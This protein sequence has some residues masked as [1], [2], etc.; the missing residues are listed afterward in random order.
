M[1]PPTDDRASDAASEPTPDA[2]GTAIRVDHGARETWHHSVAFDGYE[3]E[4]ACGQGIGPAPV[5][6]VEMDVSAWPDLE[7]MTA[8]CCDECAGSVRSLIG[9]GEMGGKTDRWDGRL[10]DRQGDTDD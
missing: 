1:V 9:T 10:D 7:G 8:G 4:T 2:P 3:H 5:L 6:D